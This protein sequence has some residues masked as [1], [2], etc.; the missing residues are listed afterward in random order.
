MVNIVSAHMRNHRGEVVSLLPT[1]T[2]EMRAGL[3]LLAISLQEAKAREI[4]IAPAYWT[5]LP[6]TVQRYGS[7]FTATIGFGAG[8]VAFLL[9]GA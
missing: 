1:I 3:R 5:D 7:I 8:K 2:D 4:T 9:T 6:V